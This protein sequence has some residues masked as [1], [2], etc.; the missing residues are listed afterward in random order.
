M[1]NNNIIIEDNNVEIKV[2]KTRNRLTKKQQYVEE[3]SNFINDLNKLIGVN[4]KNN[5]VYLYDLEN[6][7]DLQEKI[8]NLV[9]EIKKLHKCGAWGYFLEKERGGGNVIGL[10]R[11]IYRDN[12]YVITMKNKT[13][14][15][16]GNKINSVV[17]Y[18]IKNDN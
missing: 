1:S 16:N 14:E 12:D 7:N 13:I 5:Y 10:I 3:R 17:Y 9:P 4:E 8:I 6:N 11:S 15:R 18:F 2:K